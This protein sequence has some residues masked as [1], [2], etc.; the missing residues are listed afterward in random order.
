MKRAARGS[1][2]SVAIFAIAAVTVAGAGQ[3]KTRFKKHDTY[4]EVE[5]RLTSTD[6]NPLA[7]FPF[8]MH[9][10]YS[11]SRSY[12]TSNRT[13][14]DG[15]YRTE[16]RSNRIESSGFIP[17]FVAPFLET[18]PRSSVSFTFYLPT[19][20]QYGEYDILFILERPTAEEWEQLRTDRP[21]VVP[22]AIPPNKE[23]GIDQPS[24]L[25]HG[26][27]YHA[28]GGQ[29]SLVQVIA[30][31]EDTRVVP[32]VPR[33]DRPYVQKI[34]IPPKPRLEVTAEATPLQGERRGWHL[35]IDLVADLEPPI[36]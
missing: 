26:A 2:V 36:P 35:R 6:G 21:R 23:G 22:H 13:D 19:L 31:G 28:Y 34:E 33:G 24:T 11:G 7:H 30:D 8:T 27:Y 15:T 16:L 20:N 9:D 1:V 3:K 4:V 5:V 32:L 25:V 17:P 14:D 12:E 18:K 10:P 29:L